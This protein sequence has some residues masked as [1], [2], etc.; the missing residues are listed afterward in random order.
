MS[1]GRSMIRR[2]RILGFRG[3]SAIGIGEMNLL[4]AP[5]VLEDGARGRRRRAAGAGRQRLRGGRNLTRAGT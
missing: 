1:R 5:L 2:P 3:S 4:H